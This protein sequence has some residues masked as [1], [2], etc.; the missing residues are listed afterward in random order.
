VC[1]CVG[2][3]VGG[4]RATHVEAHVCLDAANNSQQQQQQQSKKKKKKEGA[5]SLEQKRNAVEEVVQLVP[6]GSWCWEWMTFV[7][8]VLVRSRTVSHHA[9]DVSWAC[10]TRGIT[11]IP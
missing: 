4:D 7:P 3:C 5:T 2:V 10:V 6:R 9:S 1:V 11:S 8:L